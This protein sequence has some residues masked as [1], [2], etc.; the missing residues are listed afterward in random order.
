VNGNP[1]PVLCFGELLLRL[2]AP[3]GEALLQ[4]ASLGAHFGGAEG[5]VAVALARLGCASAMVSTVPD[6]T[7]GDAAIESLRRAGVD[8]SRVRRAPG[9]LGLY[10]LTPAAGASSGT[11]IYDRAHSVFAAARDY[12]WP[13]LLDGVAWLHLSGIVPAL[14]PELA[15]LGLAAIAAAHDA[16]VRVSFDGNFRASLWARWCDDPGPVLAE[17]VGRADL[18]FGNRRDLSLVLG[19]TFDADNAAASKAF[20]RFAR[21]SVIASSD[22]EIVAADHHR[23][24]ARVDSR[25]G[26]FVAPEIEVTGII[27]RIGSGDAFAAGVLARLDEGLAE[28][29]TTGLALAALKHGRAGDHSVATLRDLAAFTSALTDVRR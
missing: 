28:A 29:A 1:G 21:L 2:T 9:R 7:L 6:D 15:E 12:D 22:R 10:F 24:T 8:V 23:L 26:F 19:E 17:Y 18:L 4:S 5:N 16:G 27:D 3:R 11:V 13:A 20:E 25:E 14:G